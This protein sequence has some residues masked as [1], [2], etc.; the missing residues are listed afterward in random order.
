MKRLIIYC[1]LTVTLILGVASVTVY[2]KTNVSDA[3][4]SGQQPS[5]PGQ[6]A[7]NFST[8]D[9]YLPVALGNGQTSLLTPQSLS[10][11]IN[12]SFSNTSR[13]NYLVQLQLQQFAVSNTRFLLQSSLKQRNGYYLYHLRKLLI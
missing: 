8:I 6:P 7:S 1:L 4:L 12:T 10:F 3:G 5:L 11:R 13:I 9:F 2:N